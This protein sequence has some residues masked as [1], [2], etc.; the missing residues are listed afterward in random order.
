MTSSQFLELVVSLSLQVAFVVIVTHWLGRLVKDTRKQCHLWTVCFVALLGLILGAILLPHLRLFPPLASIDSPHAATM[1]SVE[2]EIGHLIFYVWIIGAFVS[3]LLFAVRSLQ[4]S[5]FLKTCQPV[6]DDDQILAGHVGFQRFQKS[7]RKPN[8]DVQLLTSRRISTP[9]CWQFH[10]PYIVIPEFLMGFD[11]QELDFVI[12]HELEHLKTGHPLQLFLQ[13]IIE[14]IFWFHPMVWWASYQAA[15]S[16][17]FACDEAAINSPKDIATYLKTLLTI[18]EYS[19][20]KS[21]ESPTSLTFVRSKAMLTKRARRLA[22][23]TSINK[24]SNRFEIKGAVASMSLVILAISIA[25]VWLPVDVLASPQSRWS[26]WPTWSA[27]VLHDFGLT[28]PDFDTYNH[29]A[30]EI[31]EHEN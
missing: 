27:G 31:L 21:I 13:H 20:S 22:Q 11:R 26:P 15:L 14:V 7:H 12:Q 1:V 23:S 5:L 6:D 18:V 24:L 10:K 4:A 17:E 30:E 2:T 29:H 8:Q 3:L 25:F 9:F 28:A 19:T 16:R